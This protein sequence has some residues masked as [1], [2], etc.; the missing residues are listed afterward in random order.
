MSKKLL[1]ES[2]IRRFAKLASIPAINSLKEKQGYDDREDEKEGAELEETAI[3][4]K[5]FTGT[6]AQKEKKRRDDAGFEVRNESGFDEISD[7]VMADDGS[8]DTGE[9]EEVEMDA[10]PEMTDTGEETVDLSSEDVA[11]LEAA[12]SI[13]GDIVSA[14]GG[15]EEMVDDVEMDTDFEMDGGGLEDETTDIVDDET[16]MD[17]AE[18]LRGINYVP[19]RKEVI[20]E[21]AKRV[22]R[23]LLKAKKAER[24]LKEA[25]GKSPKRRTKTTRRPT[26]QRK[27][28][29]VRNASRRRTKK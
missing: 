1:S 10:D 22:A 19:G 11:D 20:N 5:D 12:M 23:R 13:I 17:L 14:A 26:A 21:V 16:E 6:Q 27:T 7:E 2:Q 29:P 25:L 28:R 24:Q 3:A 15:G 4:G 9:Q 18:A 8:L